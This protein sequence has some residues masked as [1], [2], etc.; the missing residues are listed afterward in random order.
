VQE[1]VL[2]VLYWVLI[3]IMV[4]QTQAVDQEEVRII[5]FLVMEV[6]VLFW[7]VT[8]FNNDKNY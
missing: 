7:F 1:V 6:L 8:Y 4:T 3:V 5:G 2:M